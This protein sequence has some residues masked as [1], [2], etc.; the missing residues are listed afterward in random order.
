MR[1]L[2]R[3][4]PA[5]LLAAVNR[6][7]APAGAAAALVLELTRFEQSAGRA[8]V[9]HRPK[10][11]P[12]A[13]LSVAGII[14]L[15]EGFD[16][17]AVSA[18]SAAALDL[19]FWP[20]G[21]RELARAHGHVRVFEAAPALGADF[22]H[23]HDRAA[24][25]TAVAA[26]VAGL[27][28]AP[29]VVWESSSMGLPARALST[30]VAQLRQGGAPAALWVSAAGVGAGAGAAGGVATRGLYPLLGAEVE[31]RA[32]GLARAEA[33]RLAM[34]LAAEILETGRPPAEGSALDQSGQGGAHGRAHGAPHA[35]LRVRYRDAEAGGL[36]A[37][38]LEEDGAGAP[39]LAAGA[40]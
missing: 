39:P 8:L 40:A 12:R 34:D 18:A 17:P 2:P 31:V 4:T 6:T 35:R 9:W 27:V 38:L 1:A 28:T 32:P 10:A 29:G 14:V 20:G 33:E 11:P 5:D 3:F 25:L 15:V 21:A 16:R 24:A 19:R 36:P 30:A 13:G 37:V 22:D 7:L 23:N 26:A